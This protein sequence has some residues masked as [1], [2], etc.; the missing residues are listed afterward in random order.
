MTTD[1]LETTTHTIREVVA[2][3]GLNLS[4]GQQSA[5]GQTAAAL[6]KS[7][8]IPLVKRFDGRWRANA[9]PA[10]IIEELLPAIMAI[11]EAGVEAQEGPLPD[12]SSWR[13]HRPFRAAS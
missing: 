11:A 10:S 9:I 2:D 1:C 5:I 3:L 6:C 12:G 4:A 7:R 13:V 8:G